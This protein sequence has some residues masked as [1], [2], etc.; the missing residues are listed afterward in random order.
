MVSGCL[1]AIPLSYHSFIKILGTFSRSFSC[2]GHFFIYSESSS[3]WG[4]FYLVNMDIH[5]AFLHCLQEKNISNVTALHFSSFTS[6][7]II[8]MAGGRSALCRRKW[9]GY[10][11]FDWSS[12]CSPTLISTGPQE[13]NQKGTRHLSSSTCASILWLREK[14]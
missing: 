4:I 14:F 12:L 2:S 3:V 10:V 9:S 8:Q 1:I 11:R 6:I 13:N 5:N 7:Y